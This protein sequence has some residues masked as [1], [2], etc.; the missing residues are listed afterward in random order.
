MLYIC[1]TPIGNLEDI[2]L[3]VLKTLRQVDVIAAEDTR[4]SAKLLSHYGISTRTV[5]LHQHN[6]SSRTDYLLELLQ[7]GRS[8]ALVSDSGTPGIS[9]PGGLLI[10]RVIK[11]NIPMTV[12]PGATALITALVHSGLPADQFLF[13]GF[14]PRKGAQRTR[15]LEQL[16]HIEGTLIF[17]EAP[18]RLISSLSA[19]VEVLGDR[20]VVLARELTKRYE[21]VIR[22]T[23]REVIA[24]VQGREKGEYVILVSG[25]VPGVP[26]DIS[27]RDAVLA[28][29]ALGSDKKA[30]IKT[31]ARR[32]GVSRNEVY[33][34]VLD[35]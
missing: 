28:E 27:L 30:A 3:R 5:S 19:M 16:C 29:I 24:I 25:Y 22:G 35:I 18:H 2:T 8:V 34:E 10:S 9:D 23:L 6:E 1:P 31:V 20:Q 32:Y 21:E 13:Q 33:Q 14:L 7:N 11:A 15:T 17:Y 26:Q 12:L 4:H